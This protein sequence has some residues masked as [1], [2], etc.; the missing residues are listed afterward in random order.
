[1]TS[2]YEQNLADGEITLLKIGF[3]GTGGTGKTSV[4]QILHHLPEPFIASRNR[5]VFQKLGYTG[6]SFQALNTA[7]DNWKVQRSLI[8]MKIHQDTT[9]PVGLFDRTP[10]DHLAYCM[11]RCAD[12]ISDQEW[13]WLWN[14]YEGLTAL[15]DLLFYFPIYDWGNNHEDGFRQTN[16]AYRTKID[17]LM[18][19]VMA[20]MGI[21]A[22]AMPNK[23]PE[24]RASLILSHINDARGEKRADN[25]LRISKSHLAGDV[26]G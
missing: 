19:G 16:K 6:E 21:S 18:Q 23:A 26:R 25:L 17:L 1:M 20:E 3:I 7:A 4:A 13:G 11:H 9:H 15:Y 14:K 8:D 22:I 5:E 10:I 2:E 12:A 24:E